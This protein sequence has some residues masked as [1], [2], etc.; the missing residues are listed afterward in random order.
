MLNACKTAF[1]RCSGVL[2]H[3]IDFT[4]LVLLENLIISLQSPCDP[5]RNTRGLFSAPVDLFQVSRALVPQA[6]QSANKSAS[7]LNYFTL[8][9]TLHTQY[10]HSKQ[11]KR[12]SAHTHRCPC[13][14]SPRWS[15]VPPALKE[16]HRS[17]G[18]H[19]E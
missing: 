15:S 5:S 19:A 9:V 8:T 7:N 17:S 1:L 4:Q 2:H 3:I 16:I 10:R 6:N 14:C 12:Y 11:Q 13:C 18:Y